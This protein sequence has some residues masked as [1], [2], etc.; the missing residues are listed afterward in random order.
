MNLLIRSINI[1]RA[2]KDIQLSLKYSNLF[3][4]LIVNK[5]GTYKTRKFLDQAIMSAARDASSDC[6]PPGLTH[7]RWVW[8]LASSYLLTHSTPRLMEEAS[9]RFAAAGRW[10]LS[11]WAAQKAYEERDH[12]QLALIDI[13][14]MG[15]EAE[16]VVKALI[17]PSAVALVNFFTKSVRAAD[18][19]GCIGY[20]YTMERLAMNIK[21][22]HIRLIEEILPPGT[23]ATRCLRMHSSLGSDM[24]HVEETLEIVARLTLKER[25]D[26]ADACYETA[27][28]YFTS[29]KEEHISEEELQQVLNHLRSDTYQ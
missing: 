28:L 10:S 29:L 18:P 15:Y 20:C 21:P 19:I 25:I 23:Y 26:I 1:D 2:R 16:A 11:Q 24:K 6:K 7:S 3:I 5:G 12:D 17:A 13:Q 9:Q 22:E 4:Q 14:S 8:Q 27:L